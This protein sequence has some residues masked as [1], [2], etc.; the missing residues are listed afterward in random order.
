VDH[1]RKRDTKRLLQDDYE[2]ELDRGKVC[3]LGN[4]NKIIK[5]LQACQVVE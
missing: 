5:Q 2:E 3:Y 1:D 4:N